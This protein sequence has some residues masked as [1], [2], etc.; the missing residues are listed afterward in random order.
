METIKNHGILTLIIDF[1][2]E[3]HLL[4]NSTTMIL[5]AIIMSKLHSNKEFIHIYDNTQLINIE[6]NLTCKII[7]NSFYIK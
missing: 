5:N 2:I 4:Y 7:I 3:F 1:V 6:L